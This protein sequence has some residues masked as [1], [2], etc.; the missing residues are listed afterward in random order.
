MKRNIVLLTSSETNDLINIKNKI[1]FYFNDID[2]VTV[3]NSISLFYIFSNKTTL[4]YNFNLPNYLN[5]KYSNFFIIDPNV[6]PLDGWDW[7]RALNFFN[8][9]DVMGVNQNKAAKIIIFII[10]FLRKTWFLSL[11]GMSIQFV[12][13]KIEHLFYLDDDIVNKSQLLFNNLKLK[14]VNDCKLKKIYLFGTGPS[15]SNAINFQWNDGIRLVCNTIVK[16]KALWNHI[17]PNIIVAGDAIYHFGISKF[18]KQFR[19]DLKLRLAETDTYFI[20]PMEFH[21]FLSDRLS[22]FKDKLIPIPVQNKT[23]FNYSFDKSFTLPQLGNSLNLLS[24]PVAVNLSKDINLWGYDGKGPNDKDF[25]KNSS[26]NF[27]QELVDELKLLHPAFFKYFLNNT[28]KYSEIVFG[29]KVEKN[30]SNLESE[31]Y[32]ISMLHKSW[33]KPLNK[34]FNEKK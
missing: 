12:F 2:S 13:K 3:I 28:K 16:N 11:F 26:D 19:N 30:L 17:N 24:L 22:K 20:Y 25:W 14:L 6:N 10:T 8:G 27:Y 29:N 34:R 4:V 32:T 1:H 7:H 9:L 23:N 5:F 21:S 31:N 15:L 33:T 18:S